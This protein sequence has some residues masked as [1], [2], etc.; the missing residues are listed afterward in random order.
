MKQ[1]VQPPGDRKP[2][3]AQ[4]ILF[5]AV[6]GLIVGVFLR[7]GFWLFGDTLSWLIS[8]PIGIAAVIAGLVV[9]GRRAIAR[10]KK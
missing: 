10:D 1:S 7:V 9:T 6:L 5:I 8:I 4:T 3:L 2:N